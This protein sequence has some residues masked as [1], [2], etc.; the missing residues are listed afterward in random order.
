MLVVIYDNVLMALNLRLPMTAYAVV[1]IFRFIGQDLDGLLTLSDIVSVMTS[2]KV[3]SDQPSEA[4]EALQLFRGNE[5]WKTPLVRKMLADGMR[6]LNVDRARDVMEIHETLH[7]C[8]E[9]PGPGEAALTGANF[10]YQNLDNYAEMVGQLYNSQVAVPHDAEWTIMALSM[11]VWVWRNAAVLTLAD[12]ETH[13]DE[14]MEA[15]AYWTL[16]GLSPNLM[17]SI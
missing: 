12:V 3:F 2:C 5:A 17:S 6:P 4:A 16:S 1:D 15:W 11:Q 10:D 13:L 8:I 9:G 7:S 14:I